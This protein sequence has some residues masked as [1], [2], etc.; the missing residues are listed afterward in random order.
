MMMHVVGF[1]HEFT[2][3]SSKSGCI[4]PSSNF[5]AITRCVRS[6]C[7][8][9]YECLVF[10]GCSTIFS[11][12]II[13]DLEN[14]YITAHINTQ[15]GLSI[16]KEIPRGCCRETREGCDALNRGSRCFEY[17][18]VL[19]SVAHDYFVLTCLSAAIQ[20]FVLFRIFHI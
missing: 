16:L 6:V 19:V 7:M 4:L 2:C 17:A 20:F 8:G 13:V 12:I 15:I 14:W 10:F 1:S 9:A 5:F 3:L 18:C 11:M